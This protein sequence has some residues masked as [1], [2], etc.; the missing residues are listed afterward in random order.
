ML[1]RLTQNR[2]NSKLEV[3]MRN[4]GDSMKNETYKALELTSM[5]GSLDCVNF[6]S[7][8][9][10]NCIRTFEDVY[11]FL[12]GMIYEEDALGKAFR[13]YNKEKDEFCY[14]FPIEKKK[15]KEAGANVVRV[16][17]GKDAKNNKELMS[18]GKTMA[19]SMESLKAATIQTKNRR[20]LMNRHLAVKKAVLGT[21]ATGMIMVGT[22][23]ILERA[24]EQAE[25][26]YEYTPTTE[27]EMEQVNDY[28]ALKGQ[29]NSLSEETRETLSFEE[30]LK[31]YGDAYLNGE[32]GGVQIRAELEGG[33]SR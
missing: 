15:Q 9:N 33:H 14:S 27:Y 24:A 10:R 13:D 23:G 11:H 22:I 4:V 30:F 31:E 16:Y 17:L 20:K 21:L 6:V 12:N 7:N 25:K 5:E 3:E 19:Q 2:K 18:T 1:S 8:Q 26:R 28:N 29:Y 32:I